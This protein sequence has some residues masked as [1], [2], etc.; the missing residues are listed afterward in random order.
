MPKLFQSA[1]DMLTAKNNK[2]DLCLFDVAATKVDGNQAYELIQ[3][4]NLTV[5]TIVMVSAK[6]HC[7]E[8]VSENE[9]IQ[10]VRKPFSRANILTRIK[11]CL[12]S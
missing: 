8:S 4:K 2:I 7:N 10:Q 9:R 1:I 6:E 3:Q 12:A 5:P 11:S